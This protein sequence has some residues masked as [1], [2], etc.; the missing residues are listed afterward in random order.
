[1]AEPSSCPTSIASLQATLARESFAFA[2]APAMMNLLSSFHRPDALR[3]AIA[4][5]HRLFDQAVPQRDEHDAEVYPHKGTLV[6]YYEIDTRVPDLARVRRMGAHDLRD[7]AHVIEHIDPTTNHS[8]SFYRVHRSWPVAADAN[9]I[10]GA[11]LGLLHRILADRGGPTL[12][13]SYALHEAMMSGFRVTR[14][15]DDLDGDPSPEGVHQDSAT[16]TAIVLIGRRNVARATGG[17]RVWSLAQRSGK[18]EPEDE[19]EDA[20]RLLANLMLREPLDSLLVL[21]RKVKHEGLRIA[22]ANESLGAAVRDVLTFEVRVAPEV[23]A[24]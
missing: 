23:E 19:L 5:L 1:M 24:K 20:G 2:D 3:S 21:D 22:A 13:Q 7:S 4:P 6:S 8:A 11:L 18:P 12:G 9:P 10:V 17:N 14:S 16:L 15:G